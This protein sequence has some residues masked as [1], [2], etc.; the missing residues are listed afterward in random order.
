MKDKNIDYFTNQIKNWKV[1]RIVI[2]FLFILFIFPIPWII[3][4]SLFIFLPNFYWLKIFFLILPI[5][6]LIIFVLTAKHF[7]YKKYGVDSDNIQKLFDLNNEKFK[8]F[9]ENQDENINFDNNEKTLDLVE[10][11][12]K[13]LEE[14]NEKPTKEGAKKPVEADLKDNKYREDKSF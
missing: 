3:A 1:W 9:F 7:F 4:I 10:V 13:V 2:S 6:S 14:E 8:E 12:A 11:D 5:F